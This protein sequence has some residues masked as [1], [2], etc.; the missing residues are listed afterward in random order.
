[1]TGLTGLVLTIRPGQIRLDRDVPEL[2]LK[3]GDIIL[4]YA[5]RGEGFSAAWVNGKYESEYDIG[6]ITRWPD[7]TGCGGAQCAAT[8]ID[9]GDKAWWAQVRL[10]SGR[11]GW[12]DM[13]ASDFEIYK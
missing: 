9:Q 8:Y 10:A 6:T 7:G 4:T 1:M 13:T 3:R 11:T 2:K 5:Y 12:I